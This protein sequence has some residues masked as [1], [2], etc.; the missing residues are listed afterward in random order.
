MSSKRQTRSSNVNKPFKSPVVQRDEK[1]DDKAIEAKKTQ[2]FIPLL[3]DSDDEVDEIEDSDIDELLKSGPRSSP[4]PAR[5]PTVV[6]LTSSSR[7]VDDIEDD[8]AEANQATVPFKSLARQNS[9]KRGKFK[10]RA[11]RE[12]T[13]HQERKQSEKEAGTKENDLADGFKLRTFAKLDSLMAKVQKYDPVKLASESPKKKEKKDILGLARYDH[14]L[15][16]NGLDPKLLAL[17]SDN[18]EKEHSDSDDSTSSQKKRKRTSSHSPDNVIEIDDT[19]PKKSKKSKKNKDKYLCP[20]C[21]E[22]VSQQLYE[23]YMPDLPKKMA[24]KRKLHKSHKLEKAYAKKKELGIPDIDWDTLEDR[25]KRYF[26]HLEDIMEGRTKS[27]FKDISESFLKTKKNN[28]KSRTE[29]IFEKGNW[30]KEIPGYYGPR[31]RDIMADTINESKVIK[32]GLRRLKQAKDITTTRSSEGAYIQSILVPELATRL[33]MEDFEMG[34]DEVERARK[35]M[36]DTID[37]GWSLNDDAAD[38]T[39]PNDGMD[40]WWKEQEEKRQQE[41]DTEP[42]MSQNSIYIETDD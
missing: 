16:K 40:W 30:E 5:E 9:G 14:V 18:L 32:A 10:T 23:S 25:C 31:G 4:P 37:V 13:Q 34:D 22:E 19:T 33:I 2:T 35:L 8:E 36:L 28:G 42:S 39:G 3:D 6:D 15:K 29:A 27:H 24:L 11:D 7:K 17:L 1:K 20:M 38:Y 41:E 12:K 21:D 26:S